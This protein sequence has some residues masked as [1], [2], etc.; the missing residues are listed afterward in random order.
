M[1]VKEQAETQLVNLE[2]QLLK[3]GKEL[4]YQNLED[5]GHHITILADIVLRVIIIEM[6][7]ETML[8]CHL[9]IRIDRRHHHHHHH[10]HHP[11]CHHLQHHNYDENCANWLK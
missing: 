1:Q 2:L 10:Y 9:R 5:R 8:S 7:L 11:C 3:R 4:A 6:P